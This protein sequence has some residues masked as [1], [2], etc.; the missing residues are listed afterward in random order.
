[1]IEQRKAAVRKR[2]EEV[3]KLG[4]HKLGVKLPHIEV[5]FDLRG[6]CAGMACAR[7]EAGEWHY[8][9]RFNTDMMLTSAW[10]HIFNNTIPHELGHSFCQV[11]P[12]FGRNHDTGWKRVCMALGGNAERCHNEAVTYAK[13]KTYSY[14]ATCGTVVQMSQQR[15]ARIQRG[16]SYTLRNT[17]GQINRSCQFNVVGDAVAVAKPV[18][19]AP[20]Q[21]APKQEKKGSNASL[22]RARIAQAKAC[23]ES[24]DVVIAFGVSVLGM[25]KA[26]ASTY[27]RNNWDKA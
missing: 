22:I 10:D 9:V 11:Y 4:E 12:K 25:S 19:Q 5:R 21:Q 27:V 23:G 6:R 14:T 8:S 24:A 3:I 18:Q 13:G 20:K 15:H 2:V 7:Y 17:G 26:L 1:M 16:V